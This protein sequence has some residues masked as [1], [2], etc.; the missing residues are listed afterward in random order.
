MSIDR[1]EHPP[2]TSPALLL[3]VRPSLSDADVQRLG[4]MAAQAVAAH[5]MQ[6]APIPPTT[7]AAECYPFDPSHPGVDV[8]YYGPSAEAGVA[9][10]A[11]AL[12]VA[13]SVRPHTNTDSTPYVS[14]RA[15]VDGVPVKVWALLPEAAADASEVAG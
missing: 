11:D 12:G 4:L 2:V 9:S 3:P 10:L 13:W 5:V 15:V 8:N 7:V 14:A 6:V 1:I